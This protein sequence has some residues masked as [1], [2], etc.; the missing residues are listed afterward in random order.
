MN[1]PSSAAPAGTAAH[2]PDAIAQAAATPRFAPYR[3]IHKGL[4]VLM[5]DTLHRAGALDASLAQDRAQIVDD[6]ERLL[7][8]CADHLAHENQFF[9]EPL[10]QRAPRAVRPYHEDHLEHL[11]AIAT[12]RRLLLALRDAPDAQAAAL[13]YELFLRLSVFIGENLAHMAE[14]ESALTQAL[15]EHFS[16]AEIAGM[17]A[18]LQATLAPHELAFYLHWMARGMN[19]SETI[20]LLAGARPH[21]PAELFDALAGTAQAA[22]PA[23]RWATVARAL[24]LVP[25]PG[26]VAR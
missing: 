6:V 15:W 23:P 7:A 2:G 22:M 12:L 5:F 17:E 1:R 21:L 13:G 3:F 9:H 26:L 24:G 14:E 8:T 11:D 19:A 25:V 18:A 16:D 10:R 20:G 4:R